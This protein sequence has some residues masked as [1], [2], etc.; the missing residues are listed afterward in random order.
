MRPWRRK[1]E[2]LTLTHAH[3]H[4]HAH[5]RTHARTHTHAHTHARTY[6][7]MHARTNSRS[8]HTT[9]LRRARRRCFMSHVALAEG[10]ALGAASPFSTPACA[11]QL[12]I[13]K[14]CFIPLSELLAEKCGYAYHTWTK[15]LGLWDSSLFLPGRSQIVPNRACSNVAISAESGND[16]PL[17]GQQTAI[18][19]K[20]ARKNTRNTR[21]TPAMISAA[22]RHVHAYLSVAVLSPAPFQSASAKNERH[23]EKH[24]ALQTRMRYMSPCKNSTT[25]IVNSSKNKNNARMFNQ[26]QTITES[27]FRSHPNNS[28]NIAQNQSTA[29]LLRPHAMKVPAYTTRCIGKKR[30]PQMLREKSSNRRYI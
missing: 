23:V 11:H 22:K 16:P 2:E 12:C 25:R 9:R 4:T 7:R 29:Y 19:R 1:R 18:M 26:L 20:G 13:D 3:T 10:V 5:T 27:F 28:I 24:V 15:E 17:P 8:R 6:A 14:A 30:R 21:T